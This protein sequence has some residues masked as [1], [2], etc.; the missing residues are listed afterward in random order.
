MSTSDKKI[1]C[2]E[3]YDE[4]LYVMIIINKELERLT[5]QIKEIKNVLEDKELKQQD[6]ISKIKTIIS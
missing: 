4:F 1:D 5:T 6:T 3:P 2:E